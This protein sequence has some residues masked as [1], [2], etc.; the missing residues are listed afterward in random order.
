M[1]KY[2]AHLF[3]TSNKRVWEYV[4]AVHDLHRLPAPGVRHAQGPGLPVADGP[5]PVSQF[6][7]AVTSAG[8]GER[9]DRR[10]GRPRSTPA[11]A[12]NLEEKAVSL[13]GRPLYEAFVKGYTAKQWQTD[14]KELPAARSSPGC[15]CATPSTTATSTTPT[16]ACRS[17]AT[18][19]GYENMAAD[20]RHRGPAGH[21]L[22]RRARRTR[23]ARPDVPVV[24]TGPL[25]RYFEYAAGDLGWRTLDFEMESAAHRRL[26]GH[27]GH[28]LQRPGRAIH[29]YP[30]VPA[31][32]PG[33]GRTR[34]TRR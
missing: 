17:T 27:P 5:G 12:Q 24:Y 28:E 25:D 9:A 29:P 3:H 8:R 33:A 10:A 13:I 19:P 26:P 7:G 31:F 16:R 15:R 34:P 1:H 2:G 14:P 11:D 21:R 6:F 30:R 18:P 20:D 32:P 4:A 23:A 22:V